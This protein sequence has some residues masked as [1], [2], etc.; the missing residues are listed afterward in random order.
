VVAVVRKLSLV[1]VDV[2][3]V[4]VVVLAYTT[5]LPGQNLLFYVIRLWL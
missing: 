3:A 5:P 4:V 2:V 1:V